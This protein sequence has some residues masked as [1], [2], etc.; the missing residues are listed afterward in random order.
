MAKVRMYESDPFC[1][2]IVGD[3][4]DWVT[5]Y[6]LPDEQAAELRELQERF[7][8]LQTQLQPVAIEEN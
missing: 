3:D 7:W 6:E 1:W 8:R 4:E 2:R 5:L